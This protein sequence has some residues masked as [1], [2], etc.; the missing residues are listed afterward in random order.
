MQFEAALFFIF[1]KKWR[2]KNELS[3]ERR[4]HVFFN[5]LYIDFEQMRQVNLKSAKNSR[6]ARSLNMNEKIIQTDSHAFNLIDSLKSFLF[7][8]QEKSFKFRLINLILNV[9][10]SHFSSTKLMTI[11]SAKNF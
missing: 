8:Q 4:M 1:A 11:Q 7:V 5:L 9:P 6:F 10:L 3:T 2:D